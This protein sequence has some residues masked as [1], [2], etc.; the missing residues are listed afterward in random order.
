MKPL[1]GWFKR[2]REGKGKGKKAHRRWY[3]IR[4][5]ILSSYKKQVDGICEFWFSLTRPALLPAAG[6]H[7]IGPVDVQNGKSATKTY[8]MNDFLSSNIPSKNPN[9]VD[10]DGFVA[11]RRLSCVHVVS[12]R[13]A[14]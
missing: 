9:C 8:N 12:V 7:R 1:S 3:Q 11:T 13:A 6:V 10:R 5:R 14:N 4:G 2:F